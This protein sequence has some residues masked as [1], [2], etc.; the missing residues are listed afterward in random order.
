MDND[1]RNNI[2]YLQMC[3]KRICKEQKRIV[4]VR[5]SEMFGEYGTF[6]N[7]NLD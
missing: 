7:L 3:G 5:K 6:K 4:D 1:I 2:D